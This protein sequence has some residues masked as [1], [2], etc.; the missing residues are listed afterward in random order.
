LPVYVVFFVSFAC[1]A[2]FRNSGR[3][4]E[5]GTG[6]DRS[7]HFTDEANGSLDRKERVMKKWY[8]LASIAA[9]ALALTAPPLSVA[10]EIST[11]ALTLYRSTLKTVGAPGEIVAVPACPEAVQ[12]FSTT[13][14]QCPS[15]GCTVEANVS[16]ELSDVSGSRDSVRFQS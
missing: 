12:V 8:P 4:R 14:I 5:S 11:G 6:R 16:S 15:G 7:P 3:Y 9:L 13:P 10:G 2:S 1:F